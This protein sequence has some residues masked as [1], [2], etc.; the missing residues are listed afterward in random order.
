M[1][2]FLVRYGLVPYFVG[3]IFALL[4]IG[5]M[6]SSMSEAK[7]VK[8]LRREGIAT[9]GVVSDMTKS[10]SKNPGLMDNKHILIAY[11]VQNKKYYYEKYIYPRSDKMYG[12]LKIGDEV[13]IL[14][15]ENN[16][17]EKI[18]SQ[19][20]V[21]TSNW[22]YLLIFLSGAFFF[23]EIFRTLRYSSTEAWR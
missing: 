3:I 1:E 13:T 15:S 2:D 18:L 14:Y 6:I 12:G 21:Q 20:T 16:P 22:E 17:S 8:K 5:M 11:V 23:S 9:S 4:S 10:Y 19:E 7:L